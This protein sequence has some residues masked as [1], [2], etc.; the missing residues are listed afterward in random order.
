MLKTDQYREAIGNAIRAL[1]KRQMHT[2]M[3]IA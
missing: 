3:T 2:T 1:G